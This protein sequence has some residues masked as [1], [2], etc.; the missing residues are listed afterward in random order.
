MI[1]RV[2]YHKKK[3]Y[4][5]LDQKK[6]DLKGNAGNEVL[7]PV[8]KGNNSMI[9]NLKTCITQ[10]IYAEW[11]SEIKSVGFSGKVTEKQRK[12]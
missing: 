2:G 6:A 3:I 11:M 4:R 7:W 5:A 12:Q 1:F 10:S 8:I 9:T